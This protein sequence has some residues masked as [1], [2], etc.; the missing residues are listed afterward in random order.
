[1]ALS[2][3]LTK[4]IMHAV[5]DQVTAREL[6]DAIDAHTAFVAASA[7]VVAGAIVATAVSQTTDFASLAVGDRV[8]MIPATAGNADLITITV[9]GDLGQAAVIGN[10]YVVLRTFTAPAGSTVKL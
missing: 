10:I 4:R 8:L 1:M 2:E 5:G 9:A 3:N 7:K 6:V